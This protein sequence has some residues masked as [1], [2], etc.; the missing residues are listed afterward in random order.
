MNTEGSQGSGDFVSRILIVVVV[1]LAVGAAG[2]VLWLITSGVPAWGTCE[3][4][5]CRQPHVA[6][7]LAAGLFVLAVVVERYRRRR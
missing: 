6:V 2:C 4:G 7:I 1:L 5:R 3:T